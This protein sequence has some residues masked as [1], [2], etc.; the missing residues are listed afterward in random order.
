[1]IRPRKRSLLWPLAFLTC[2][3]YLLWARRNGGSL[4]TTVIRSSLLWE[5][6]AVH[7]P[8]DT[9]R[10]LP[11]GTPVKFPRVQAES[12]DETAEQR[13]VRE[14]RRA[15]VKGAFVRCWSSYRKLAWGADELTPV[16]GGRRNPFGGWAATL[17]DA[18]DTLWIMDMRKEFYDAVAAAETIDFGTTEIGSVNVFETTIRYLGG[19]LSA[20]DLSGDERLL[21]KAVEVGEMVYKAFDTPNRMPILRWDFQAAAKGLP[22]TAAP[23][24]VLIAEIGSLSMELTRLSMVTGDPKW[25]DAV[26]RITNGLAAHQGLSAIPGLW[27]LSVDAART[28]FYRPAG[29]R[30]KNTGVFTLG[31]M[32][33]SAYEYLPKMSALLGGL[34]E[35]YR[36]MY[37]MAANAT[38]KYNLFRPLTPGNDDILISGAVH[39]SSQVGKV[40]YRLEPQGQHLVCFLGGMFAL[41]GRLFERQEDLEV[42]RKLV[43]G[44]VWTYK[45]LPH[46][47]MPEA[48]HMAACAEGEAA[49]CAW[50]EKVWK[51]QVMDRHGT[52]A[53]TEEALLA[54]ADEIIRKERLPPGFTAIGDSRY[55]LRPEAIESVFVLHRVTGR[56]DLA[57]SAWDMF[58]AVETGTRTDLAN[59]AVFDVTVPAGDVLTAMDSME[60]F[61]LGETLKYFY[62]VFSE[63]DLI[64]LDEY[65]FN[66]EAHPFKRLR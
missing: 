30:S 46:G 61:W 1:M 37:E 55:I 15:A 3:F 33:D 29:E 7:F 35:G 24:S 65:V 36:G 62:L 12:P 21:R 49:E 59:S 6:V 38:I 26:Q 54:E 48:F 50:D 23:S 25:F 66:T 56:R 18:L 42:A 53:E 34:E 14:Q 10:P 58:R 63:P 22:Q 9:I 5:R 4:G 39:V 27:P 44:C 31:A 64:S 47:V 51:R 8:P 45:A 52:E 2:L 43:D 13:N 40:D 16:T 11:T 32:A 57:E 19:F 41:G 20:Y 60:S 28:I 17:V